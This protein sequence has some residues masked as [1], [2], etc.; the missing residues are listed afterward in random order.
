MRLENG[1]VWIAGTYY[2]LE[3][4]AVP[5]PALRDPPPATHHAVWY[6]GARYD[7]FTV[8]FAGADGW[9]EGHPYLSICISADGPA[10][11]R[12]VAHVLRD[13]DDPDRPD[14]LAKWEDLT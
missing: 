10:M 2:S 7:G 1:G 9:A 13:G 4:R 6:H 8:E 3:P 11:E 5:R 14:L 12:L